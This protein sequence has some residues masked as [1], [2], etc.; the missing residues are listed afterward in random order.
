MKHIK[1][2]AGALGT[3]SGKEGAEVHS[4]LIQKLSLL[5]H[6]GNA[7]LLL[8]RAPVPEGLNILGFNN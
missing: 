8:N 1:K 4:H 3:R 2:L 5:L 7:A 6:K